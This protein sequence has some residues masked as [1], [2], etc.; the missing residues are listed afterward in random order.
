MEFEN[1]SILSDEELKKTLKHCAD[2]REDTEKFFNNLDY[3]ENLFNRNFSQALDQGIHLLDKLHALDKKSY[4]KI[5][6]GSPFYWLGIAA[7]MMH[8]YSTGVF[9]FDAALSEDMRANAHPESNPTPAMFFIML[10]DK[11][12][13]QAALP[14]VK[15]TLAKLQAQINIYNNLPDR[16]KD[17]LDL[18]IDEIR[19]HFL[20]LAITSKRENWSTLATSMISF[21]LEWNYRNTFMDLR[22]SNGTSEPFLIHLLKGCVMFESLLRANPQ[23]I[24]LRTERPTLI[25]YLQTFQ[26]EL[27]IPNDIKT[28]NSDLDNIINNL[29]K[30][31]NEIKSYIEITG[32][33]RNSLGHNISWST[34]I[35]KLQYQKMF[36]IVFSSCLHVIACLYVPRDGNSYS[37][38]EKTVNY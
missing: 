7:F 10:E 6:K 37:I 4:E 22:V 12:I 3:V 28:G 24:T 11:N 5:H 1:G 38:T 34:K 29:E 16:Q 32:K 30:T 8:D 26:K 27:N 14:L 13:N 25:D 20:L 23:E 33:L 9:F 18:A 31:P 19:N 15:D 2:N 35:D 17:I 36:E 21:L